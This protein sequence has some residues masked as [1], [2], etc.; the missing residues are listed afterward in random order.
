[1]GVNALLEKLQNQARSAEDLVLVKKAYEFAARAHEGQ[2]RKSG[3]PYIIHPL[4][5]AENLIDFHLDTPTIAAALL[6]DVAEDTRY[7]L[8][9]LRN[10]FGDEI[11]FLV[12]GVT[13]LDKIRYKGTERSAE[14]L[15]KMFLA[16][17]EDV[18]IVLLKLVD[19]LHN[20]STL[21]YVAPE[22]QKRIALETLE[23]YAPLAYRLGI[24]ELKGQLEDLAFPYV[25][26]KEHEWLLKSV[27]D[28]F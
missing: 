5:V 17:A 19:R 28:H 16:I 3:E 18:R 6:H 14:S 23:I 27:K 21:K 11:A 12:E 2:K 10:E 7:T 24:G 4:A 9:D 25:Y 20:M 22:K 26:P 13:K 8:H 15:R 1:M